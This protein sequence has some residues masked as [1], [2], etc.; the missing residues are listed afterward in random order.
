MA[1]VAAFANQKG[2]VGKTTTA[3]NVSAYVA[4][5]GHSTLLIDLDAQA[6]ASS[7]LGRPAGSGPSVHEVLVRSM[8]MSAIITHTNIPG[9]D[10]LPSSS[11][12]V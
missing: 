11:S 5:R 10:I 2:G 3:V 12:L 9:L 7:A 1:V 4:A 6:N 8:P